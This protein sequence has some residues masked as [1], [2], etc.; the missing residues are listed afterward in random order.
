MAAAYLAGRGFWKSFGFR[1]KEIRLARSEGVSA[2]SLR[3]FLLS[4][5]GLVGA[6]IGALGLSIF[7]ALARWAN[8]QVSYSSYIS[9]YAVGFSWATALSGILVS[10][11]LCFVALGLSSWKLIKELP[12]HFYFFGS[13]PS[14]EK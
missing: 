4:T 10:V 2:A 11:L 6:F 1:D 7:P 8:G 12:S 3:A 5:T 14:K 13:D 9:A